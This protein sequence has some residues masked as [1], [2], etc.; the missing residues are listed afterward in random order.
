MHNIYYDDDY[1]K[2]IIFIILV[3]DIYIIASISR[4]LNFAFKIFNNKIILYK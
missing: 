1:C 3:V 2:T 4:V